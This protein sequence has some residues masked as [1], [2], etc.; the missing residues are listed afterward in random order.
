MTRTLKKTTEFLKR[1]ARIIA[2]EFRAF[3][4][5]LN[6]YEKAEMEEMERGGDL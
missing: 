5:P 1:A 2:E 3:F 4:R 6:Q